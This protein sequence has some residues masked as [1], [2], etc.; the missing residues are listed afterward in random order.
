MS[1]PTTV[2]Q[3]MRF[4]LLWFTLLTW[5]KV[6]YLSHSE[7]VNNFQLTLGHEYLRQFFNLDWETE[8][9]YMTSHLSETDSDVIGCLFLRRYSS[10]CSHSLIHE[11]FISAHPS[12]RGT[13]SL[14]ECPAPSLHLH[15]SD[16]KSP[17]PDTF[18]THFS[19]KTCP[20]DH[21]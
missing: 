15:E 11:T 7:H 20:K 4:W 5:W 17:A 13:R 10:H 12:E 8:I 19:S 16:N 18:V 3:P 1:F 6:S 9:S 21:I 14:Q 2:I